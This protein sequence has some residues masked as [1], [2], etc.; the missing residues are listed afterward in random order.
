MDVQQT[1]SKQARSGLAIA[2]LVL[3]IVALATSFLP[4]IN[5]IS[6]FIA[7]VGL[8]LAI[9]GIVGIRKGKAGGMGIGVAGLVLCIVAGAV[10]LGS[11]AFYTAALNDAVDQTNKQ[12]D[13][14]SGDA[15]DEVL[16]VDVDV[17][18]GEFQISKDQYGIIKSGLPVKITNLLN[19]RGTYW[20]TIEA[21]DASGAR[22]SDDTVYVNDLGANQSTTVEAFSYVSSD[23]YNAMKSAQFSIVSVSEM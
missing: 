2:A 22:I 10:V 19:E 5:N 12:L 8:I 3:G 7:L 20:I 6:F 17:S 16:G 13:K 15:T 4:I 1:N 14:M 21:V 23:D 18:F 11:Q 9:I